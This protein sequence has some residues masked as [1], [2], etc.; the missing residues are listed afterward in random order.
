MRGSVS[1]RESGAAAVEFVAVLGL[2]VTLLFGILEVGLI[3][4]CQ[5]ALSSFARE[6]ARSAAVHGGDQ[7]PTR[8]YAE[9][10]ANALGLD[11]ARLQLYISPRNAS[12]GTPVEVTVRYEYLTRT[13]VGVALW[14][15]R[16][17]LES[18]LV[19]RSERIRR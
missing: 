13:P 7:A 18:R 10:L 4:N 8:A 6:V 11:L 14:A 17:V 9:Y 3:M 19:S 15:G 2:L 12:Y 5:L 1:D 16:I